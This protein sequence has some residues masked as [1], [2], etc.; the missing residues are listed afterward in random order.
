MYILEE[1]DRRKSSAEARGRKL[2]DVTEMLRTTED[3]LKEEVERNDRLETRVQMCLEQ[4]K[5][6]EEDRV[7]GLEEARAEADGLREERDCLIGQ[8]KAFAGETERE[9]KYRMEMHTR[10]DLFGWILGQ[11]GSLVREM[12]KLHKLVGGME[13][14]DMAPAARKLQ[15][16]AHQQSLHILNTYLS[17]VE[18]QHLGLQAIVH[19]QPS[20][21]LPV[22]P[23]HLSRLLE[24]SPLSQ[25]PGHS[26]Y[27]D[28]PPA[29]RP[30]A[31]SAK[32][33]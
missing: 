25:F 14:G 13:K 26:V 28:P 15:M 22:S 8:L 10:L 27:T 21:T 12:F 19:P 7:I 4:L 1:V 32:P 23:R 5:K 29:F 2:A 33:S 18:R 11:R 17:E 30:P 6:V 31:S 20:E 3:D 24:H 16:R 9:K